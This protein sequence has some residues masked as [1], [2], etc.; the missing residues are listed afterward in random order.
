[1]TLFFALPRLFRFILIFLFS[2]TSLF[3][4]LRVAFYIAFDNTDAPLIMSDF[5]K[6]LW[7]GMRFDLR[8]VVLMLVPLF[9]LGGIKWFS[10]FI[11]L[12][13]ISMIIDST[14]TENIRNNLPIIM[15]E[16]SIFLNIG[17][18]LG[19]I[20]ILISQFLNNNKKI[21]VELQ[22]DKELLSDLTNSFNSLLYRPPG[23]ST[24]IFFTPYASNI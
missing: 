18:G 20:F 16:F 10:P 13:F 9:F 6:S 1:M 4:L 15:L 23:F 19:G 11:M 3:V 8:M 12:L 2:L 5:I 7:L 22:K 14:L 21:S 24:K 17:A